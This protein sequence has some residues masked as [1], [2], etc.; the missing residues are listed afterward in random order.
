LL[1][2]AEAN[3]EQDGTKV[4]NNVKNDSSVHSEQAP[5]S[6]KASKLRGLPRSLWSLAM[7]GRDCD[8]LS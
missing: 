1:G 3:S 2:E 6:L 4:R 7:T 5:Q 8:M